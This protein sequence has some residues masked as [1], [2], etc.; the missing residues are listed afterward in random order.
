MGNFAAWL[1]NYEQH[2]KCTLQQPS[3]K[4]PAHKSGVSFGQVQLR[5]KR[6]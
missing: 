3:E 2:C 5:L 4:S 6:F 1:L